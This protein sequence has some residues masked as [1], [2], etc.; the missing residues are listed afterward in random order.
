MEAAHVGVEDNAILD[1]RGP[2]LLPQQAPL[3]NLPQARRD[4]VAGAALHTSAPRTAYLLSSPSPLA[5]CVMPIS[6]ALGALRSLSRG[7]GCTRCKMLT[8]SAI[9]ALSTRGGIRMSPVGLQQVHSAEAARPADLPCV[10]VCREPV[11]A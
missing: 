7:H 2:Q 4:V 3:R 9:V 8:L 5:R 1:G 6:F 10:R 11:C